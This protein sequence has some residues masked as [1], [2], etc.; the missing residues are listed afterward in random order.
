MYVGAVLTVVSFIFSFAEI[1]DLDEA[2]REELREQNPEYTGEELEIAEDVA[3][4]AAVAAVFIGGAMAGV[5]IW[6]AV[7]NSRGRSWARVLATI[8]GGLN[9]AF[10]AIGLVAGAAGGLDDA[11][12]GM[13]QSTIGTVM[14]IAGAGLAA[15]ILILLY[16]PASSAYYNAVTH[17]R[18]PRWG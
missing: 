4:V 3:K 7:M 9:I 1:G 18:T 13:E 8:L 10:T 2:I 6:M 12:A 17:W 16:Q 11:A 14:S 15:V 5:W